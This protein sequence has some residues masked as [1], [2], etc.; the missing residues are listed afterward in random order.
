MVV[1]VAQRERSNIKCYAS[2]VSN[3]LTGY[4][5]CGCYFNL[6]PIFISYS[7]LDYRYK[8]SPKKKKK[9]KRE[10]LLIQDAEI[11]IMPEKN[12]IFL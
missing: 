5:T 11:K 3:I 9:G 10:R 2:A 12:K 1:D 6:R 7:N 8:V 4:R